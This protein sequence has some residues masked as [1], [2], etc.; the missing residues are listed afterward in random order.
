MYPVVGTPTANKVPQVEILN[1][2]MEKALDQLL[3]DVLGLSARLA[4]VCVEPRPVN[5]NYE[6]VKIPAE[7]HS[8]LVAS[9]RVHISKISEIR[10]IIVDVK[11]RLEI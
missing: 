4:N 8:Q 10:N 5:K 3:E 11:E 7:V 2:E 9:M 1:N 6:E